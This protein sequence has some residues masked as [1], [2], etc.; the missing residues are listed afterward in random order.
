[1]FSILCIPQHFIYTYQLTYFKILEILI[2]PEYLYLVQY[3]YHNTLF[4]DQGLFLAATY[5]IKAADI[6]ELVIK[7]TVCFS[8]CFPKQ[9]INLFYFL[10]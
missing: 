8:N 2:L 4:I 7:T 10:T 1:M 6:I 9:E 3:V 5:P